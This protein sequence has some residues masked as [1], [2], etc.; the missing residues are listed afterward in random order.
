MECYNCGAKLTAAK[1]CKNCGADV[2]MYRRI[3][4]ASNSF[5][6][7]G[8]ERAKVRDLTGAADSLKVSLLYNKM[9]IDARN[10]LGLVYFEMGET[11]SALSEW[12]L[13]KNYKSRENAA[14]QSSV[15]LLP[16]GQQ[17]FGYYSIKESSFFESEAGKRTSA[18]GAFVYAGRQI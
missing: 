2:R 13:S 3:L 1:R 4:M 7:E 15:G 9:N 5:Y 6:N 10:L 14:S 16:A 12:V 8:L 18:A 11:V 17:G